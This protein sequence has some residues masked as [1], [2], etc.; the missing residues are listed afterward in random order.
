VIDNNI[1][2]RRNNMKCNIWIKGLF[3]VTIVL[4]FSANVS[5]II[6][7]NVIIDKNKQD[8]IPDSSN[9]YKVFMLGTIYNL[10]YDENI[11]YY[12]F[13]THNLRIYAF[14]WEN[15]GDWSIQISRINTEITCPLY[16]FSFR[17]IL[18]PTFIFG[19]FTYVGY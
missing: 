10:T 3:F 5:S 1:I 6:Q 7:E 16:N 19:C 2:K 9:I 11:H 8:I 4:F 15:T 12:E 18:K 13:T 17:G 14:S